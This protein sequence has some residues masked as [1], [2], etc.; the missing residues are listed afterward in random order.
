[1]IK[2]ERR[3]GEDMRRTPL[4]REWADRGMAPSWLAI[5]GNKKSL[6]LDLQNPEAKDIVR[7]LAAKADV[8]MENFRGG[9]MDRLGLGYKA[10]SE[11][12]PRLI[13]CAISGFGQTGPYS[14]EAGY[15][16]KMQALSG[17]MAITGHAEMGPTRAGFAVCDVLSG[18][19]AAFA[20]SSA[21]FQRTHTGIGQFIDVS[22]L[23][24]SL[25]FLSTQVADYTVAGHRQLQAGNQAISRKVTANLFRAKDS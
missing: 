15:D 5:N 1:M 13:Y 22:M 23:E 20:V 25:A 4:S 19:T 7:K 3:G 11:I 2:V 16:G 9:V 17:I 8:V 6:T 24:A 21:L 10:L 14:H 18:A 12:D